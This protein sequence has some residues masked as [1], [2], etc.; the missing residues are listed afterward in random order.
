MSMSWKWLIELIL[1]VLG[2][3]LAQISPVVKAALSEFLTRLY[4]DALKTPNPW[5][6]F[7]VGM[8]L[9]ILGIPRP[10]PV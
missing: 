4:L 7:L 8:L 3:I 9:D 1:S 2:P 10:P 6:D 5:D